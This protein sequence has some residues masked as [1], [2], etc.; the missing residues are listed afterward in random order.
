MTQTA[1]RARPLVTIGSTFSACLDI[2]EQAYACALQPATVKDWA[3]WISGLP[4]YHASLNKSRSFAVAYLHQ[5]AEH[6]SEIIIIDQKYGANRDAAWT[7]ARQEWA[8]KV[9]LRA[10]EIFNML[11]DVCSRDELLDVKIKLNQRLS[12]VKRFMSTNDYSRMISLKFLDRQ[13]TLF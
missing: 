4:S 9:T 12:H 8:V 6:L 1:T 7:Q 2:E 3:D 10:L 5:W 11:Q 13:S